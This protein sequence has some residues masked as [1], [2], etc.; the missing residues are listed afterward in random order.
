MVQD[1]PETAGCSYLSLQDSRL[2]QLHVSSFKVLLYR[3]RLYILLWPVGRLQPRRWFL[4]SKI[5][6]VQRH[7]KMVC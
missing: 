3:G 5:T 6:L 4:E 2:D 7:I 1:G